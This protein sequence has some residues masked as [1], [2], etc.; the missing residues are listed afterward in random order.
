MSIM[1]Q[2][3]RIVNHPDIRGLSPT[4][5][6]SRVAQPNQKT[7]VRT[8]FV[9]RHMTNVIFFLSSFLLD[10]LDAVFVETRIFLSKADGLLRFQV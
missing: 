8:T 5:D 10:R 3:A 1:D 6:G 4:D 2:T 7:R 9:L